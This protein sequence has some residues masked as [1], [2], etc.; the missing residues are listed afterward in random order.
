[1]LITTLYVRIFGLCVNSEL[2][3]LILSSL[4]LITTSILSVLLY[5]QTSKNHKDNLKNEEQ[6]TE[7][8]RKF[9]EKEQKIQIA[10]INIALFDKRI[11]LYMDLITL[12]GKLSAY[13]PLIMDVTTEDILF[14]QLEKEVTEF[15]PAFMANAYASEF[16]FNKAVS[17]DV[18]NIL[19]FTVRL[20]TYVVLYNKQELKRL[21]SDMNNV[22]SEILRTYQDTKITEKVGKFLEITI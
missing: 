12:N 7:T 21:K 2:W 20:K 10:S 13:S 17:K 18:I 16:I 4:S 11:A 22:I 14:E 9:A 6:I 15:L 1:M 5:R 3:D 8:Q 19:E